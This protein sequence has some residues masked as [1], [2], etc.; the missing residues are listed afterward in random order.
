[1]VGVFGLTEMPASAGIGEKCLAERAEP[2]RCLRTHACYMAVNGVRDQAAY[3][4]WLDKVKTYVDGGYVT[5][6]EALASYP[7]TQ[8]EIRRQ[9]FWQ[10]ANW[11]RAT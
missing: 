3:D 4:N 10:E 8:E 6:R 9:K 5:M 1:M 11:R 7:I 2:F